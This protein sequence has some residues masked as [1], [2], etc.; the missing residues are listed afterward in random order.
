MIELGNQ[1]TCI[2]AQMPFA[3]DVECGPVYLYRIRHG[4]FHPRAKNIYTLK[5]TAQ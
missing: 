1:V 3:L 5:T 2:V 4:T